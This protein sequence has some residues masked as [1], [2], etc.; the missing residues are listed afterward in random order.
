MNDFAFPI[1]RMIP[2]ALLERLEYRSQRGGPLREWVL[3]LGSG[4]QI[5]SVAYRLEL[6]FHVRTESSDGDLGPDG[7]LR[8][9]G[10]CSWLERAVLRVVDTVVADRSRQPH[11]G[12]PDEEEEEFLRAGVIMEREIPVDVPWECAALVQFLAG[13]S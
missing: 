9:Y 10:T 11:D 1:E 8:G 5:R 7:N 3:D 13:R 2:R 12:P 4:D 6:A